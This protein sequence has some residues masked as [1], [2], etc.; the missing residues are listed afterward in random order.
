[1]KLISDIIND[2]VDSDKS[3][4]SALL[5]TKV[6]ATRIKNQELLA[7]VSSELSGF[8]TKK[9]LPDYRTYTG[10][11]TGTYINGN[12]QYNDQPIP[13]A[14]LDLELE[15][16]LKSFDFYQSISGL[17]NQQKENKSGTLEYTFPAEIIGLIQHN[18]RKMG[19]PYLQLV[20]AKKVISIH[21]V[22][23]IV[24]TVR[25]TL[26]DFMLK[27][28][29]EFGNLTEIEDLIAKK[30]Q[31]EQIM[32]QTIIHT[33]GHGNIINTGHLTGSENTV[34]VNE[35]NKGELSEY[36][37]N[38]SLDQ[39]SIDQILAVIDDENYDREK[40]KF[41]PKVNKWI[42][43]QIVKTTEGTWSINM[44]EAIDLISKAL[45]KYY[46]N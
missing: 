25:N 8:K 21:A 43:E 32:S 18:W 6:L 15:E 2:L 44:E 28:D 7:W 17:E 40:N 19:N 30:E 39:N 46:G 4:S 13:T 33:T 16:T 29:E 20:N 23:E 14:G 41:G 45:R 36:L 35:A 5:K 31:I 9:S 3:I 12:M 27:I 26:L 37:K 38:I 22:T 1:M 42:M 11:I 34:T 10:S 24:S